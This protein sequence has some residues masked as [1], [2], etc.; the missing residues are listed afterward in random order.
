MNDILLNTSYFSREIYNERFEN[1]KRVVMDMHHYYSGL[2][3][4]HIPDGS[5]TVISNGPRIRFLRDGV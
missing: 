2:R 1:F 3:T 4:Q 5:M